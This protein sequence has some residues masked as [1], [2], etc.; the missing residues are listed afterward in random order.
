MRSQ[1]GDSFPVKL[2]ADAPHA[3]HR[4]RA[5]HKTA[6]RSRLARGWERVLPRCYISSGFDAPRVS[7]HNEADAADDE[8]QAAHS[9]SQGISNLVVP[10]HVPKT[11]TTFCASER[12]VSA[13]RR[14]TSA[15]QFVRPR[16]RGSHLATQG[17]DTS[18]SDEPNKAARAQGGAELS[19]TRAFQIFGYRIMFLK[20]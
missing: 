3:H 11:V 10:F 13:R 8:A 20:Q 16:A 1:S 12:R 2:L 15:W 17:R 18:R 19:V 4:G 7:R 5:H 9:P 6:M 14:L